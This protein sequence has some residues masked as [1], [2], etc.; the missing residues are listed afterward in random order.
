M[1]NV[2]PERRSG[3]GAAEAV[4]FLS[5]SLFA[6]TALVAVVVYRLKTSS[7]AVSSVRLRRGYV[8]LLEDDGGGGREESGSRARG[9]SVSLSSSSAVSAM[10]RAS[11]VRATN[12]G[13]VR[14]F[15]VFIFVQQSMRAALALW[16]SGCCRDEIRSEGENVIVV[17]LLDMVPEI[18]FVCTFLLLVSTWAR[19][20]IK[21]R[22]SYMGSVWRIYVGYVVL[23]TSSCLAFLC[24]L[25]FTN[26]DEVRRARR[27]ESY[28][29]AAIS[30]VS[31][32][33]GGLFFGIPVFLLLKPSK[34]AAPSGITRV[35]AKIGKLVVICS[36]SFTVRTTC[37]LLDHLVWYP[38]LVDHKMSRLTYDWSFFAYFVLIEVFT[39][40][41]V[42]Y[43]LT[44]DSSRRV[45]SGFTV[46]MHGIDGAGGRAS[47]DGDDSGVEYS[48]NSS[49]LY[50][51]AGGANVGSSGINGMLNDPW[52]HNDVFYD[53]EDGDF[54]TPHT[55][56]RSST[57]SSFGT[58]L[59]L[60]IQSQ[61][62]EMALAGSSAASS[63][64]RYAQSSRSGFIVAGSADDNLAH[65][66]DVLQQQQRNDLRSGAANSAPRTPAAT[67]Y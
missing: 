31:V 23:V 26:V 38:N 58:P 25:V 53:N 61:P 54:I 43:V 4:R 2:L 67:T 22:Y 59:N 14:T 17:V 47:I 10:S 24:A 20:Y 49:H 44:Q 63:G 30:I 50:T 3:E 19:I 12:G 42:L 45:L 64:A 39:I 1:T 62:L 28:F 6:L 66:H 56:Y 41:S 48:S 9:M 8:P 40:L 34:D 15:C 46:G 27:L 57:Q 32:V 55:R 18:L 60:F 33:F 35:Y 51:S 65:Q 52:L 29:I 21:C 11:G 16:R 13:V 7:S 36:L 37:L 5:G